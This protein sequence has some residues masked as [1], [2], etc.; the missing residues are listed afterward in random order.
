MSCDWPV[1]RTCLPDL[2]AEDDPGYD[3]ALARQSENEDTAV[4]VLWSLSGRQ[5]GLC[6]TVVRPCPERGLSR[7]PWSEA[8]VF[9]DGGN[10]QATSCGCIGRCR[11]SGPGM[12]HLPG[13][14]NAVAAV[15][16]GADVLDPSEYKLQD[17][18]LYRTGGKAWPSQNLGRP[19]PETGTWS[20]T[21]DRG[22]PVPPGGARNA[23]ILAR[24]FVAACS[25]DSECRLPRNVTAVTRQGVSYQ[26]YNPNDMYAA[27]KTGLADVDMWLAAVNPHALLTAPTVF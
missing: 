4:M 6:E 17:N 19:T 13:P 2:P 3:A 26:I 22:V 11:Q 21:Y 7:N 18:V 1:D 10:W 27:G 20:V 9:W 25:D 12:I 8:I 15:Q 16:L 23:G 24:E 14:A 5:F